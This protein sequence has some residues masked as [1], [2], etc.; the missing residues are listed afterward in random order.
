MNIHP[1]SY[2]GASVHSVS[3]A[4]E[5]EK[6][7][8]TCLIA[9]HIFSTDCKKDVPPRGLI[10]LKEV[11]ESVDIPVFG[12]GGIAKENASDVLMTGAKGMCIMSEAMTCQHPA[13]LTRGFLA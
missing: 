8:A 5:A 6:L 7:G 11:C 2:V 10:F 3:E 9:G 13:E 4:K 1:F 12:I